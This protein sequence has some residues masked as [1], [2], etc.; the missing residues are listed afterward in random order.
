[1][2]V[3]YLD[4]N[5]I[6][7]VVSVYTNEPTAYFCVSQII[8]A[9]ICCGGSYGDTYVPCGPYI[10]DTPTPTPTNTPTPSNTPTGGSTGSGLAYVY[11]YD[12]YGG[13]IYGV[14]VNGIVLIEDVGSFPVT[15][16]GYLEGAYV[17]GTSLSTIGVYVNVATDAP[18]T[19]TVLGVTS[20]CIT[21]PGYVEFTNIDLSTGPTISIV[22]DLQGSACF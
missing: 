11:N 13:T 6:E 12:G 18:V 7:Q 10:T 17:N 15:Y 3:T 16:G 21:T 22:M 20:E 5:G 19:L 9:N 8:S 14:E 4:C 2:S 1:V